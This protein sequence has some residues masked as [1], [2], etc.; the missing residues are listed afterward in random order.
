MERVVEKNTF[1][2]LGNFNLEGVVLSIKAYGSGHINDT[3]LVEMGTD[4]LVKK[5]ILQRINHNIF[6]KPKELMENIENITSYLREEIIKRGGDEERETLNLVKTKDNKSYYEDEKGAYWRIYKFIEGAKTYD[7]VENIKDFYESAL[8]FGNFQ[9]L[10][11]NYDAGKLHETIPDFHNTKKRFRDFKIAVEKAVLERLISAK[12]DIDFVLEN[13]YLSEILGDM[14]EKGELPLRVTHND[15]KLNNI[16]I[17]DISRKAICVIDLD[18]VMPGLAINDFGDS[19]RFGANKAD[20]DEVDI[21]K[22]GIDLNLYE[23]YVKGFIEACK[24]SLTDKESENLPIAAMVMT[25]EC[26]MRFLADY[27]TGDTYFK[28]SRQ[29]QN[30][31]RARCQFALVKD[32]EKNLDLMKDIVRKYRN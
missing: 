6:K 22:V 17:D 12:E 1:D 27:L 31:D 18:T 24:G 20:E 16:M 8:A 26:G 10:L 21:A 11:S 4:A 2:V 7:K 25:Y 3:F 30:L 5:Y 9:S 32:M 23:A 28:T 29:G 15:T 13:K 19:I 14:L